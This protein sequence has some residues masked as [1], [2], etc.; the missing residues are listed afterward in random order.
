MS[1]ESPNRNRTQKNC[2][3]S[4]L[5]D[6]VH[7]DNRV[8]MMQMNDDVSHDVHS[9]ELTQV[10]TS[11]A[12]RYDVI[13]NNVIGDVRVTCTLGVRQADFRQLR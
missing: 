12:G 13:A 4:T 2:P 1:L 5:N 8:V 3:I 10:M 11:D 9:L 6:Y 7:Y